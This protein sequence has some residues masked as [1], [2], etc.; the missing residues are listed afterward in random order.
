MVGVLI[1]LKRFVQSI[2]CVCVHSSKFHKVG[3]VSHEQESVACA[4]KTIRP[5]L[6]SSFPL[7]SVP[8][9]PCISNCAE[10]TFDETTFD[11]KQLVV[12]KQKINYSFVDFETMEALDNLRQKHAEERIWRALIMHFNISEWKKH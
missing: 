7:T 6:C 2:I 1:Q 3:K 11:D 10:V 8:C 5:P 9:G 12:D 4:S